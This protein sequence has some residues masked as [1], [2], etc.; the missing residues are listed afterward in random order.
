MDS[1]RIPPEMAAIEADMIALRRRLHAHPELGF[2]ERATSDLV[3]DC[4][5]TWGYQVTRGLGGTGV[6][7][8]LT[9]GAG[10][11]LG[12]RADMDALPIRETTGLPHASRIDGVMH[13]CGHDGH[14]AMLLAAARC[15]AERER[16]HGTLNLLFQP[17]EEGLGGAQRMIDDGLFARFPCDAVFAMHNVPGLPA[18]KLGFCD[19]PFMASADEVRVRVTGRGGHGAAP[20]AAVDPVVVCAS[21]VMALQTIV[22]RNVNPQALA[23]ITAGSIHAG[24]ASNVIPPHADLELSVRALSPD[25]RALLERRIRETVAG[26]AASYGATAE[27]DYCVGYP[28]LVNHADETAFA[29]QVARDWGGDDALIEQL[30]PIAAS[31]DFAFM[32]NAC[33]GSYLSIGNGDGAAGCTLHNPGYDFNDAILA[34]GASYWVALAERFLG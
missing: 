27:I 17:A 7:G 30:Q 28:V 34:T 12:L 32:L 23:I 22:S 13:A 26:Q 5:T 2:E 19:G 10:R 8:T 3:A 6:V 29:R 9:R 21:I 11:R 4:L 20:H 1:T 14:T 18:G 15:L 24:T 33:P 16:F 25:V 31:E